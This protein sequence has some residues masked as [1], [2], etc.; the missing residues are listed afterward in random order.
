MGRVVLVH[1]E[2]LAEPLAETFAE[3]FGQAPVIAAPPLLDDA[4][5]REL[6]EE[7]G[8]TLFLNFVARMSAS[9]LQHQARLARAVEDGDHASAR[10]A[11]HSLI[12]LLGH[13]G[14]KR[15]AALAR[16]IESAPEPARVARLR[17]IELERTL[18]DSLELLP[19]RA[20]DFAA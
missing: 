1:F 16:Q 2:P 18:A 4:A 20:H 15:A 19:L 8:L 12:G 3:T 11:A 10:V 6:L 9:A 13:F 7:V 5:L 17:L 14:L